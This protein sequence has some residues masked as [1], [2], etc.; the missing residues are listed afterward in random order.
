MAQTI[1]GVIIEALGKNPGQHKAKEIY[2]WVRQVFPGVGYNTFRARLSDL[3]IMGK[4]QRTGVRGRY[5]YGVAP[6]I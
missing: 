4:V 2:V 3:I 6:A 1:S 5:E